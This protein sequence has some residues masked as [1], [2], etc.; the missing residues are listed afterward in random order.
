MKKRKMNLRCA[1]WTTEV[2]YTWHYVVY[3]CGWRGF[4]SSE[5]V[6]PSHWLAVT[7]HFHLMLLKSTD[8]LYSVDQTVTRWNSHNSTC[9]C[10]GILMLC[11][12]CKDTHESP[13]LSLGHDEPKVLIIYFSMTVSQYVLCLCR[14][15]NYSCSTFTLKQTQFNT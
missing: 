3:C 12:T 6:G 8:S 13:S 9:D 11:C 7:H 2:N 15:L 14:F 5:S 4:W 1:E 10:K